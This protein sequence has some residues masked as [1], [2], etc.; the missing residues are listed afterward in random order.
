MNEDLQRAQDMIVALQTQ[1]DN[2]S[3]MVVVLQAEI[4]SLRRRITSL[5][6]LAAK[7][8]EAK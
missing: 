2:Y 4:A 6:E 8:T 1:R 5:E 7:A 3:N